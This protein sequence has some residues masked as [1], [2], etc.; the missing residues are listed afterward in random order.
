MGFIHT[1]RHLLVDSVDLVALGD[2]GQRV[3]EVGLGLR[4]FSF[5]LHDREYIAAPCTDYILPSFVRVRPKAIGRSMGTASVWGRKP[6]NFNPRGHSHRQRQI[7][8]LVSEV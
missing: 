2:L 3:A 7:E 8:L 5:A 1:P 6:N 4:S